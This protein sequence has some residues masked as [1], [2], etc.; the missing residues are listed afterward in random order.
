MVTEIEPLEFP[1]LKQLDF[2][3]FFVGLDGDRSLRKKGGHTRRRARSQF[4]CCFRPKEKG[5]SNQ[6]TSHL[7]TQV[8]KCSEVYVGIF[9]HLL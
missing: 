7:L 9:E 8:A 3:F 1:D 4:G 2:F 5:T 6:T